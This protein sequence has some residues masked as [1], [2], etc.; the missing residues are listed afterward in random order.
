MKCL[1]LILCLLLCS[2]IDSDAVISKND[3]ANLKINA[4]IYRE[5]GSPV[6][7]TAIALKDTLF[8]LGQV[9]PEKGS[10]IQKY[11]W[12]GPDHTIFKEYQIKIKPTKTGDFTYRFFIVDF[13]GDSLSD[14]IHV[15]VSNPP[16]LDTLSI[17]PEPGSTRLPPD[18]VIFAWSSVDSENQDIYYK[19]K[20]FESD[21]E[22][23]DTTLSI[24]FFKTP[25]PLKELE[26]YQW[27]LKA[28]NSKG[29]HG[30]SIASDFSTGSPLKKARLRGKV[31]AFPDSLISK[32]KLT[33]TSEDSTQEIPIKDGLFDSQSISPGTYKLSASLTEYEDYENIVKNISLKEGDFIDNIYLQIEDS[34][35]PEFPL[36]LSDTLPYVKQLIFPIENKGLPLSKESFK[37]KL[38][39]DTLQPFLSNDTLFVTLPEYNLPICRKLYLRVEDISKNYSVRHFQVCPE[40][41]WGSPLQDTLIYLD[42]TL[43]ITFIEKNPYH[44]VL[45]KIIWSSPSNSSWKITQSPEDTEIL[46]Y[47]SLFGEGTHTIEALSIYEN[48]LEL[49]NNFELEITQ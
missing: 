34:K 35:A 7:D 37:I 3:S 36:Y 46:L 42:D 31:S 47:A 27:S 28:I 13:H 26:S 24:S 39:K 8:L 41:A 20:L 21:K 16:K 23:L 5:N 33:L 25:F 14:S 12:E 45:D 22:I 18:S 38:D 19:F 48:G 43:K 29:I 4:Y 32:I 10:H 17:L 1:I 9:S 49:R 6:K 11:F 2:C 44:L 30:D 15:L 40:S